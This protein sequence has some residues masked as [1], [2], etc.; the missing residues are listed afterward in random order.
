VQEDASAVGHGARA[1]VVVLLALILV[2]V[3]ASIFA[4]IGRRVYH[5]TE[6]RQVANA[7]TLTV[8][9]RAADVSIS[10]GPGSSATIES[11]E[12][13]TGTRA[14]GQSSIALGPVIT[15]DSRCPS[16]VHLHLWRFGAHC[17]VQYAVRMPLRSALHV[18][19]G[20]GDLELVRIAGALE[21]TTQTGD[22][23]ASRIGSSRATIH[24]G[25]GDAQIDF[26]RAPVSLHVQVGIGDAVVVLPPGRYAVDARTAVGNVLIGSGIVQDPSSRRTIFVRSDVGDVQVV[27]GG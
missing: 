3:T 5:S 4:A 8:S 2:A 11:H 1:R 19:V 24:V 12:E 17:S 6:R 25:V 9:T 10:G 14:P 23:N 16:S 22:L 7:R 18:A 13:W 15:L 21:T 27:A 26:A 20:S